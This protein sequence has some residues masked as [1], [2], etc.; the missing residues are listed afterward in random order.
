MSIYAEIKGDVVS[1]IISCEDSNIH[2]LPGYY[3]KVINGLGTPVI[4]GSYSSLDN[5]FIDPK[6]Y[7]SWVLNAEFKW[8]ST[9]GANPDILTKI[10]DEEN[11]EWANRF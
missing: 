8:E 3:I 9:I 4:G 6:P 11:Q 5:K 2:I 10:W 1:N 7:E